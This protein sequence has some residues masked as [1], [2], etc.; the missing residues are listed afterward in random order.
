M[1]SLCLRWHVDVKNL[2]RGCVDTVSFLFLC[3][4]EKRISVHEAQSPI[5]L[6]KTIVATHKSTS[7]NKKRR[8]SFIEKLGT[9]LNCLCIKKNVCMNLSIS[10]SSQLSGTSDVSMFCHLTR[11][12]VSTYHQITR[13]FRSHMISVIFFFLVRWFCFPTI[14]HLFFGL[15]L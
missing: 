14:L 4:C 11:V 2:H 12:F 13:T 10:Q 6:S 3:A 8:K 15:V 5:L 9:A 1:L 7:I